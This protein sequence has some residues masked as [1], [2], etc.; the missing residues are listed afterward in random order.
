MA[1]H[2]STLAWKIPY[3]GKPGRLQPMGSQRVGHDRAIS[4]HFTMSF[5]GKNKNKPD[6]GKV[7]KSSLQRRNDDYLRGWTVGAHAPGVGALIALQQPLVVLR[8]WHGGHGP[9]IGEAE[10]LRKQTAR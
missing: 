5:T 4:F 8:W 2:S 6:K 9:P 3:T 7:S 10:T 1:T